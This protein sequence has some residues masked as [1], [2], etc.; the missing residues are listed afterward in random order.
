[1]GMT[2]SIIFN[3]TASCCREA[4]RGTLCIFKRLYEDN[5]CGRI[6]GERF[7]ELSAEYEKE[8]RNLRERRTQLQAELARAKEATTNA[9][10]FMAIVRKH[11]DFEELTHTLLHEFVDKIIVHECS[12]DESGIR[13]QKIENYYSFVGKLDLPA[14]E[15]K[16]V[17]ARVEYALTGTRKSPTRIILPYHT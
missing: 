6:S 14:L 9:E 1:M 10:Q 4:H 2:A 12:Y 7:T 8:Q 15:H 17:P 11:T 5:V 13:R 3:E 16:N